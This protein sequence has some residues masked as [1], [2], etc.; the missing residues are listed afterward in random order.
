MKRVI[1]LA[2]AGIISLPALA[3]V[4]IDQKIKQVRQQAYEEGYKQGLIDAQLKYKQKWIEEGRKQILQNLKLYSDLLDR[5]FNYKVLLKNG[6]ILPP[7]VALICDEGYAKSDE[8]AG[9]NCKYKIVAHARFVNPK[10]FTFESLIAKG[11]IREYV[12]PTGEE[13][14]I[15]DNVYVIGVYD[16]DVGLEI[17]KRLYEMGLRT[18]QRNI[19]GKLAI[20]V[21]ESSVTADKMAL[22][23]DEFKPKKMSL[24][25]FMAAKFF[26][27]PKIKVKQEEKIKRVP[28]KPVNSLEVKKP[29]SFKP[30]SFTKVFYSA[31]KGYVISYGLR[32]RSGPTVYSDTIGWLRRGNQVEVLDVVVNAKGQKWYKVRAKG[33]IGFVYAKYV[34]VR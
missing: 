28:E 5:I 17:V 8:M 13:K 31:S 15:I 9:M 11:K 25:E 7:Q 21:F 23:K 1:A 4:D 3:D 19:N 33:K 27:K 29:Y 14:P 20:A 12:E 26:I 34:K 22:L 30:V 24:A 6:R 32:L 18:V 2:L 10:D 16:Y